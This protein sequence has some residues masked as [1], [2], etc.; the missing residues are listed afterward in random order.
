MRLARKLG[1]LC[2]WVTV[3]AWAGGAEADPL[4]LNAAHVETPGRSVASDETADA[5]VVNPANL[6]F[7]PAA[8][9]RW[10]WVYCP[11][12]TEKVG[13]G[14]A[15][16][17]ATPLFFGLST[18]LRIDLVQPPW[19]GDPG[20]GVGFPFRGNDLVWATWALAAKMG[21]TASFGFS[22]DHSYSPNEYVSGLTG[23]TAALSWRPNSH[24]GFSGVA[25]DFNR[26]SSS[27]VVVPFSEACAGQATPLNAG[28]STCPAGVLDGR[29]TVAMSFRPT[30]RRA[31]DIG[32]EAQYWEGIN[33]WVPRGTLGIDVPSVGRVFASAEITHLEN[34]H[35]Q[36]IMGTAGLELHWGGLSAGG[37][38]LFGNGLGGS[39]DA[40]GYGTIAVAGYTQPGIPLP[41]R[42]IW[43]R[44]EETPGTLCHVALMRKLWA[45]AEAKDVAA[46]TL[47]L[48]AEPAGSFAHAEEL[49]DAIRVLRAH[50]KKV[51]CSLEDAGSRA[52]YVCA[53][54]DRTVI[55]P[56]GAIR[57]AGLRSQYIYLKGLLDKIG[58]K[59]EFVRIGPHKS[60]LEQFTNEH[61]GSRGGGGPRG[62]APRLHRERCPCAWPLSSTGTWTRRA[63]GRSR[64]DGPFLAQEAKDARS[65]R[66]LRVWDDELEHA[67]QELVG[68][69]VTYQKV[70]GRDARPLDVR[71][72][73]EG[74][75]ALPRRRHRRRQVAATPRCST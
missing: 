23:L 65:R 20:V 25:R 30:G 28:P 58:V 43:L 49:A 62:D 21:D 8:E 45:M 41:Q 50:H 31:V 54:A 34:D 69:T 7:L 52:L 39:G 3:L 18:G 19:G 27:P 37:G 6:A 14:H 32:L 16:E 22:V 9:L 46:V 42:S 55:M 64:S 1:A 5:I 56:G 24:F 11:D 10:T 12:S 29:Y 53:N 70:H 40:A 47:L 44:I 59:A 51:L 15:W 35:F 60:A 75:P 63:S 74:G 33:Q 26:P 17:V 73:R 4:P 13:C 36:G 38:A 61:A 68:K 72:A 48:R 2:A 71:Q 57:Y 67:T 66:R